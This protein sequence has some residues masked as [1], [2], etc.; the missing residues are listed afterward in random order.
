MQANIA[1][2]DIPSTFA[3][4]WRTCTSSGWRCRAGRWT[5]CRSWTCRSSDC[6]RSEEAPAPD[7]PSN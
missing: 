7:L 3:P 1:D 6:S 5:G 4:R 2:T